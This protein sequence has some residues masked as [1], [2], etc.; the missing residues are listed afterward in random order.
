[1]NIDL[2]LPNSADPDE[3]SHYA[4]FIWVS[5]LLLYMFMGFWYTKGYFIAPTRHLYYVQKQ[6][7]SEKE[8]CF[9]NSTNASPNLDISLSFLSIDGMMSV[10]I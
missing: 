5:C 8:N 4:T 9:K 3:M 1:M 6:Q 2:V 10:I 7:F